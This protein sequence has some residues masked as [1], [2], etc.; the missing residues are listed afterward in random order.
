MSS[1]RKMAK[2]ASIKFKSYEET[3]Q[4]LLKI[5]RLDS[6]LKKYDSIVLKIQLTEEE[7]TSTSV[8]FAESVLAFV[9]KNKNPVSN[10]FI[11]EGSD[12]LDTEE[13]FSTR[14][15]QNLAEKYG[16]GLIDLNTTETTPIEKYDFSKF[17][18]IYYPKILLDS[19]VITLTKLEE[20]SETSL[21]GSLSSMLGC[22]PAKH[23]QGFF[24]SNKN[25]IRKFPIKYSIHDILKCKIPNFAIVDSSEFGS[26]MAGI[27][28]ELDKQS[29]KMLKMEWKDIP[30]LKL[31]DESFSEESA[32]SPN[33]E[34]KEEADNLTHTQ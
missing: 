11:A 12:G 19:F 28:I 26:L 1:K 17:N 27:P 29:A 22:F 8:E 14:G 15:Y 31:L 25:K 30:Y 16:I 4:N 24:S 23:Y 2:G 3:S 9:M 5:L 18:I 13:L 7:E 34:K 21:N 6:E 20:N 10:V 33:K 32:K